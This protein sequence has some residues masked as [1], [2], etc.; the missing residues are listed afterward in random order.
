MN[1]SSLVV[2][3]TQ[4]WAIDDNETYPWKLQKRYPSLNVL[5]YGTGGYGSYQSFAGP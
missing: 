4:G 2:L 3:N 5:N 1:L